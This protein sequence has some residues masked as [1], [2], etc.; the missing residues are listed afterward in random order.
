M[1]QDLIGNEVGRH[2]GH[3]GILAHVSV[4]RGRH[5][6][7]DM[8]ALVSQI[9]AQCLAQRKQRCFTGA[10]GAHQRQINFRKSCRHVHNH[11]FAVF[12]H[13][14][15]QRPGHAQCAKVIYRHLSHCNFKVHRNGIAVTCNAGVIHQDIDTTECGQRVNIL[16]QGH[17]KF[18]WRNLRAQHRGIALE[19]FKVARSTSAG[20][21]LTRA[22]LRKCES[23]GA[24]ET[25]TGAGD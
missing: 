16:V 18:D 17:I 3:L 2:L 13:R 6:S 25:A 24:A 14:R 7:H 10:V 15:R 12:D 4:D 21:D 11:S 8:H 5:D 1:A 22:G 9:S 20:E 23:E 19:L